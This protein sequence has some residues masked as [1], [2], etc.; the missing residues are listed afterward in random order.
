MYGPAPLAIPGT[1]AKLLNVPAFGAWNFFSVHASYGRGPKSI[2]KS[3]AAAFRIS[4][5]DARGNMTKFGS[6][7][8]LLSLLLAPGLFAADNLKLN[9]H[10][11]Y[12]SD[13]HDG[14]L[15][16]GDNLQTGL[17]AGKPN[18]VIIYAEGCFNS[19]QQARRT[20]DLYNK[21]RGKVNFV[22][23]DLDLRASPEQQELVKRYYKGYIPHV[24]VLSK[25]GEAVYN[26]SG[27]V[28]S[29]RIESIFERSLGTQ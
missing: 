15:I 7:V 1:Y 8:V 18:Y 5:E 19:K 14:P 3:V 13:S 21:Y 4:L 25:K 24:V 6:L 28:E 23:I 9:S 2:A 20:V 29:P 17:V 11:D 16:T 10:L 26:S 22:V 27:E 12:S